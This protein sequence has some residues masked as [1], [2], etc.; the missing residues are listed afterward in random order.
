MAQVSVTADS[1]G[2]QVREGGQVLA[3]LAWSSQGWSLVVKDTRF[4]DVAWD[5]LASQSSGN[6]RVTSLDADGRDQDGRILGLPRDSAADPILL[7]NPVNVGELTVHWGPLH[8]HSGHLADAEA[9]NLI[10]TSFRLGFEVRRS[11]LVWH[12]KSPMGSRTLE[13]TITPRRASET[14][15]VTR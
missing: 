4:P 2:I 8:L 1:T 6:P 7:S 12:G 15:E 9:R 10:E 14:P 5:D 3:S 11:S 13:T